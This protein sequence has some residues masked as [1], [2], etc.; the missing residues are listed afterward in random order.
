MD[1]KMDRKE[2]TLLLKM[3]KDLTKLKRNN[4][5]TEFGEGQ[6]ILCRILQK[7]I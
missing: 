7:L 3:Y 4:Q 5:L 2:K 1:L 6:L